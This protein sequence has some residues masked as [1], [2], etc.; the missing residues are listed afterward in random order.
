LECKSC[1]AGSGWL[2]GNEGKSGSF[3]DHGYQ[4]GKIGV[5]RAPVGLSKPGLRRGGESEPS[6]GTGTQKCDENASAL[7]ETHRGWLRLN[8]RQK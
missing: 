6:D 5:G 2:G 1:W 3:S 4:V 7:C 8:R